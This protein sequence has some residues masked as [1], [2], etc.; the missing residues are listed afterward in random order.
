M[1]RDDMETI[2]DFY[3]WGAS[4]KAVLESTGVHAN[5]GE[6]ADFLEEVARY[7]ENGIGEGFF[8]EK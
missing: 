7:V 3:L 1:T 5:R 8:D 6:V 4:P 2:V